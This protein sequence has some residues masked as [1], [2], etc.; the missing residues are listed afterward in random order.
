MILK[1][2]L[3]LRPKKY[4][5]INE[6][7]DDGS[8]HLHDEDDDGCGEFH[9]LFTFKQIFVYN[10][11]RAS[12]KGTL[13]K[14]FSTHMLQLSQGIRLVHICGSSAHTKL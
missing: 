11:V 13:L 10:L 12:Q 2:G 5:W 1:E 4:I 9:I 8:H 7:H 3:Q 6:E 14:D